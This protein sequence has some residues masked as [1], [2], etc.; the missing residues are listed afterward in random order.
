M[1]FNNSVQNAYGKVIGYRCHECGEVF[2][3][4]WGCICNGCVAKERRHQE[5]L[6]ALEALRQ[7]G[8]T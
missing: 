1:S 3:S 8:K 6:E 2:Q 7:L 5:A 4:M